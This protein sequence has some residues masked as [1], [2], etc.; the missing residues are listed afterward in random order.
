MIKTC[1][2]RISQFVHLGA[3][4]VAGLGLLTAPGAGGFQQP[5]QTSH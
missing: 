4:V 5:E 3:G 1:Q 2:P